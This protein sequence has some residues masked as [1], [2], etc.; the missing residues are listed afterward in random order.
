MLAATKQAQQQTHKPLET[1]LRQGEYVEHFF[2]IVSGEVEIMA[3]N[4]QSDAMS[5]ACLGPGQFFGEVEL[6]QGGQS[7]AS[8]R[9]TKSGAVVALLPKNTFFELIDGSPLTREALREVAEKRR[10]ENEKRR[11]TDS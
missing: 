3:Q 9:A 7:I 6:T 1:I 10:A 2:M 8:V 11:K 4:E 5:L